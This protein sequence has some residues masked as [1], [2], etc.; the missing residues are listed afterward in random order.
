MK[1]KFFFYAGELMPTKGQFSFTI[2]SLITD[3][4]ACVGQKPDVQLI[5]ESLLVEVE[6]CV[7][8][9]ERCDDNAEITFDY[10]LDAATGCDSTVTE[11]L[12]CRMAKCPRC[13]CEIRENTRVVPV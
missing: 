1:E 12:M 9:C 4:F 8:A 2:G 10:L 3:R 11:H 13:R 7:A 6:E 5:D